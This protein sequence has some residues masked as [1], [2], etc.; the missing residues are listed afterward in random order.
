MKNNI[1]QYVQNIRAFL[2]RNGAL[3]AAGACVI[4]VGVVFVLS[5][6]N[7]TG[8][9]TTTPATIAMQQ[10]A[11][12]QTPVQS[13]TPTE[14]TTSAAKTVIASEMQ[15]ETAQEEML[16]P[17]Q[18]LIQTAFAADTL[19]YRT[20]LGEWSVHPALDIQAAQGE[21]VSAVM[22]GRVESVREERLLGHM[23]VM[24]HEDG[25]RS[26]YASLD[27]VAVKVGDTLQAGDPLGTVGD[28]A[29]EEVRQGPHLH[30]VLEKDGAAVD[31]MDYLTAK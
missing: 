28:S 3:C 18:G 1:K 25:W 8:P 31:P 10:V 9:E 27:T 20:T 13:V 12:Q 29:L 26:L 2:R 21:S 23:V 7:H 19:V 4:M 11:V 24:L 30:F 6:V 17:V 16:W 5:T 15:P 14:T 22:K